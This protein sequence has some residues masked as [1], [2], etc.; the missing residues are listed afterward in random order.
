MWQ[1]LFSVSNQRR[2]PPSTAQD[3][4]HL[5]SSIKS[6]IHRQTIIGTPYL[7]WND[8]FLVSQLSCPGCGHHHALE[9]IPDEPA[10]ATRQSNPWASRPVAPAAAQ[11]SRPRSTQTT[12]LHR[13]ENAATRCNRTTNP[14]R[15]DKNSLS[16]VPPLVKTRKKTKKTKTGPRKSRAVSVEVRSIRSPMQMSRTRAS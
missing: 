7:S 1:R 5:L 3:S 4:R 2:P 8:W 13:P 15:H 12:L 9:A 10:P 16:Q 11:P 14:R 6:L